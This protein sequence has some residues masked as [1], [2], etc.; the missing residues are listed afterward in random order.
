M[1]ASCNGTGG[2]GCPE[3]STHTHSNQ[4]AGPSSGW[5]QPIPRLSYQTGA[6]EELKSA[7]RC[8][9]VASPAGFSTNVRFLER[10]GVKFSYTRV[11][12][13]W[14][15][16]QTGILQAAKDRDFQSPNMYPYVKL[17]MAFRPLQT[18][19]SLETSSIFQDQHPHR[20]RNKTSAR[21]PPV[22]ER[23]ASYA[24]PLPNP[25]GGLAPVKVGLGL[26]DKSAAVLDMKRAAVQLAK[27]SA[28]PRKSAR[29][30]G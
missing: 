3:P 27:P 4:E 2:N 22:R 1:I 25:S 15:K 26:P 12:E 23:A 21:K 19:A 7:P 13:N 9:G 18:T 14:R 11:N 28:L 6:K 16:C 5:G 10:A 24:A 8:H 20:S 30:S 29:G 17:A